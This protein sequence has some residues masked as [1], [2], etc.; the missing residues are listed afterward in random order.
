MNKF[1][2]SFLFSQLLCAHEV[3]TIVVTG[4]LEEN[5]P[6]SRTTKD[7]VVKKEILTKSAIVHKNA[8]SLAKA[9]DLEPGVQTTL[10][11][12]NCGS[13]R[14]T[15]NGLRGENTT[16]LIDG[17]PAFSSVSS[18]YG[19]EAIPM[20]GIS[21]LE[22]MR[23][24]GAS[25][26]AP[27]SI[28]GAINL[29]T[30]TPNE[31]KFSY[32]IRAGSHQYF[33]QEVLGSYGDNR[34]G[35]LLS[36]Q[37]NLMGAFDE[38]K[39]QVAESS[40]QSQ[41]SVF[42]K[43][44]NRLSDS[45][46]L[47]LRAGYQELELLGGTTKAYRPSTYPA[48]ID[49]QD[50]FGSN[51]DIRNDYTGELSKI[52]DRIRLKRVDG[53][54]SLSLR[55]NENWSAKGSF[56]VAKQT[57]KSIYS[58]GYDY[59]NTD[60]FRFFDGKLNTTLNDY[61]YLTIGIDHRNEDMRSSSDYLY[62]LQNYKRDSFQFK[63]LGVYIQDEWYISENDEL[64]IVL[65]VDDMQVDWD[66]KR[67]AHNRLSKTA[68][69]P[70]LHYKRV[71]NESF[72]SRFSYG[73]G[74][75]APL[76]MFESQHGTNEEGFELNITKLELAHNI[77][78]T[79]NRDSDSSSSALSYAIT[80]LSHMAYADEESSPVLFKNSNETMNIQTL[81]ALHV[82]RI[83]TDWTL[84]SSFDWFILP[85]E[86]KAK[87]PTAAQEMRARFVSDY[88]FGKNELVV[89]ANIT[90]PRKLGAYGYHKNYNTLED[91]PDPMSFDKIPAN[92]KRQKAP[93]FYTVDLFFQRDFSHM[94]WLVGVNNVFDY[95]QTKKGESPLSWRTH[96]N[97]SHLDNRHVWGPNTGRVIY[98]GL[99]IEL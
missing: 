76:S 34:G 3:D 6:M 18:F 98:T 95:T 46:S 69:A 51:R 45:L 62:T 97:H 48:N 96:R 32:Q 56:A 81:G 91:D 24:A 73:V 78:Y 52:G 90:G 50:D 35:I 5:S 22:I 99:K 13:Q 16:V 53:G 43:K 41:K 39:N 64:N 92:Q 1:F 10:T 26:T 20:A 37:T 75:R 17:I 82:Q 42:I 66:D 63:T 31:K 67:L 85:N 74:Y 7:S 11:C 71:H 79:L 23:G 68:L 2:L 14:I 36:A 28:G 25:L 21:H 57:Q 54:G 77:T 87:L 65:R 72:S 59:N 49:T 44:E 55:L 38:D 29:V 30:L 40:R 15:L 12:A 93:S 60:M 33:N 84:E 83:N 19:M 8:T 61:H 70:R 58:H 27:E 94:S 4:K 88:H 86:Y 89:M 80:R 9:V 47:N